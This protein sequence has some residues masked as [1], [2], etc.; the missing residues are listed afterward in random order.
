[1]NDAPD[2]FAALDALT[3]A[4]GSLEAASVR[5]GSRDERLK[6]LETE[7][8][9]MREDRETLAHDLDGALA[10]ANALDAARSEASDRLEHAIGA[11]RGMLARS[12]H[13]GS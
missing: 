9:L 7:L 1:M 2:L 3:A 4:I 6:A 5:R 10:R 11:I 12:D 8:G 13:G